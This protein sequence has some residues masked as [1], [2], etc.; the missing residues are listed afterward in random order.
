METIE[1]LR[2]IFAMALSSRGK[3]D[4]QIGKKI[5]T[6]YCFEECHKCKKCKMTKILRYLLESNKEQLS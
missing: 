6:F 1:K 3:F 4:L 5:K 2:Q